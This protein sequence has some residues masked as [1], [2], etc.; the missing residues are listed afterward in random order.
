MMGFTFG[1]IAGWGPG[2]VMGKG[3]LAGPWEALL[4]WLGPTL[5]GGWY[6]TAKGIAALAGGAEFAVFG[7][8]AGALVAG[9]LVAVRV[10]RSLILAGGAALALVSWLVFLAAR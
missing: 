5:L 4:G 9:A 10:P 7:G 3:A 8:L 1:A 2:Y 6:N